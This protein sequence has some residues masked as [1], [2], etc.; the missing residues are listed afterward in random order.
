MT[1][2]GLPTTDNRQP[3]TVY[4]RVGVYI[5]LYILAVRVSAP[6]L[7]WPGSYLLGITLSQFVAALAANW[8][9][10]RIYGRRHLA[11]LGLEWNRSSMT[12]LA[13]GIAGGIGSAAVV[14]VP[15]PGV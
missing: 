11:D 14:L 9:A 4:P 3:A 10:L 15:P 12:N 5:V 13:L 8:I 6:V 7:H 2:A 1:G